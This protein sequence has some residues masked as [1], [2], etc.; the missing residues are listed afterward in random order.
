MRPTKTEYWNKRNEPQSVIRLTSVCLLLLSGCDGQTENDSDNPGDMQ[1]PSF[2]YEWDTALEGTVDVQGQVTDYLGTP[3]SYA[4]VSVGSDSMK[5][6]SDGLFAL[7]DVPSGDVVLTVR[8]QDYITSS[9]SIK[10]DEDAAHSLFVP[11]IPVGARTEL[12][13]AAGG[14]ATGDRGAAAEFPS[15]A[16]VNADGTAVDGTVEVAITP[17]DPSLTEELAAVPGDFTAVQDGETVHL[18]S[19]G[20]LDVRLSGYSDPERTPVLAPDATVQVTIPVAEAS[21]IS[22]ESIPLWYFDESVASWI[23]SGSAERSAD[24]KTYVASIS[25]LGLW[26]LDHPYNLT[27]ISGRIVNESGEGLTDKP[28]TVV[29]VEYFSRATVRTD[30]DGRFFAVAKPD[31]DVVVEAEGWFSDG[32]PPSVS[33]FRTEALQVHTGTIALLQNDAMDTVT[34]TD[35]GEITGEAMPYEGVVIDG[36][37]T[38]LDENDVTALQSIERITG[39]LII[40]KT[41]LSSVVLPNLADVHGLQVVGNSELTTLSM[42]RLVSVYALKLSSN[43]QLSDLSGLS[44]LVRAGSINIRY[45]SAFTDLHDLTSLREV[46]TLTIYNNKGL[47]SLSGLAHIERLNV[48]TIWWNGTLESLTGLDNLKFVSNQADISINYA[49]TDISSLHSLEYVGFCLSIWRNSVLTSLE[50]LEGLR[51]LGAEANSHEYMTAYFSVYENSSLPTCE[52]HRILEGITFDVPEYHKACISGN[53]PDSC[54]E[55]PCEELEINL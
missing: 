2:E 33:F 16:F 34:C 50:G 28:L 4:T 3:I 20:M 22:E 46:W 42:P 39:D 49:L 30:E 23:P 55:M 19:F 9:I 13:A 10:I 40:E 51:H 54:E 11:L 21:T 44:A 45:T 48:L 8:H 5:T 41:S 36:D 32:W 7:G 18:E 43:K 52:A 47:L 17:V 29:G 15:N 31:S 24:G 37:Y 25:K 38:I 6:T 1:T 27:C 14:L 53:S 35:I 12:D 26:N